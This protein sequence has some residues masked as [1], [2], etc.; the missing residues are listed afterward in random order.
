M[1]K[2]YTSDHGNDAFAQG[3]VNKS[4]Q[5][6]NSRGGAHNRARGGEDQSSGLRPGSGNSAATTR[7]WNQTHPRG[8]HTLADDHAGKK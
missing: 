5:G 2:K 6:D 3:S 7:E 4:Y 8:G 1:P